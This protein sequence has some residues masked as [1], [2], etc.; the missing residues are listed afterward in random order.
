MPEVA[1][2]KPHLPA[3]PRRPVGPPQTRA[4]ARVVARRL[5]ELWAG[6]D[7]RR[8]VEAAYRDPALEGPLRQLDDAQVLAY[9]GVS[10]SLVP[11][12]DR[13]Q[14][15]E[16]SRES[17][18]VYCRLEHLLEQVAN[19]LDCA[20]PV[21]A[22]ISRIL[23]RYRQSL[24]WEAALDLALADRLITE[25]GYTL[26]IGAGAARHNRVPIV[27]A[28]D[29]LRDRVLFVVSSLTMIFQA[30]LGADAAARLSTAPVELPQLDDAMAWFTS[31]VESHQELDQ[32][33]QP[34][35]RRRRRR[36]RI[37]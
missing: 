32:T 30:S 21:L 35:F 12:R 6:D 11:G 5:L 28:A 15:H 19:E 10:N 33:S 37:W 29:A 7:W 1:V 25:A 2:V 31:Y 4:V 27:P 20:N 9:L 23:R 17:R 22:D 13:I 16:L 36:W 26:S 18:G 3:V 8:T 14:V 24:A 34:Q